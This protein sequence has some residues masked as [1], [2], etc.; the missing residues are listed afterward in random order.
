LPLR[1]MTREIY[2]GSYW[3]E[4]GVGGR[5]DRI[6]VTGRYIMDFVGGRLEWV[7]SVSG[8]NGACYYTIVKK[9]K[10]PQS[11]SCDFVKSGTELHTFASTPPDSAATHFPYHS[12]N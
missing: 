3:D 2:H 9:V 7:E 12:T 1:E 4:W 5:G 10:V 8:K 11:M 6:I